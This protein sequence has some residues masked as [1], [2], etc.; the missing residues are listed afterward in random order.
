MSCCLTKSV[1]EVSQESHLDT[2]FLDTLTDKSAISWQE[3]IV[4]NGKLTP[5]KLDTGAE[6]TAISLDTYHSLQNVELSQPEKLLS[7]PSR[8]PLKVIGQFQ[9]HFVHMQNETNLPIS[10]RR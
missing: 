3:Q 6:V 10:V 1:A 4:L 5:F 7:G 9:G 2:A 8:K